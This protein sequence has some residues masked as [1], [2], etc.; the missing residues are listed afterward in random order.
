M[1]NLW[2]K[3]KLRC[4]G[5]IEFDWFG[6]GLRPHYPSSLLET[7]QSLRRSPAISVPHIYSFIYSFATWNFM[8]SISKRKESR[9]GKPRSKLYLQQNYY[10]SKLHNHLTGFCFP[11]LRDEKTRDTTEEGQ[12][13][14]QEH[15]KSSSGHC[16]L[17]GL[18]RNPYSIFP[19]G[20]RFAPRVMKVSKTKILESRNNAILNVFY[21]ESLS[22]FSKPYGQIPNQNP[23]N[24]NKTLPCFQMLTR[25]RR[26]EFS[27]KITNS[28][29]TLVHSEILDKI[30][31][32]RLTAN[33]MGW[34]G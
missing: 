18:K 15:Q 8:W 26:Q 1:S 16:L 12:Q 24:P 29:A 6:P 2:S 5:G 30:Y 28:Q 11:S 17:W 31:P 4:S 10:N 27:L 33:G 13:D 7:W 14:K 32:T 34:I 22:V 3:S 20:K 23:S 9:A 25:Q 19:A 21:L